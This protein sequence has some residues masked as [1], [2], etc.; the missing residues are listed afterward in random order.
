MIIN[1][2]QSLSL[3]HKAVIDHLA[4][5]FCGSFAFLYVAACENLEPEN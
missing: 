2:I 1:N 4:K 3:S 5:T